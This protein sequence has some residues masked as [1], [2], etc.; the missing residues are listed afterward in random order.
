M[1]VN[2][3]SV[4]WIFL[5][6]FFV[7]KYLAIMVLWLTS[8]NWLFYVNVFKSSLKMLFLEL[9]PE[10]CLELTRVVEWKLTAKSWLLRCGE[11]PPLVLYWVLNKAS[12][13]ITLDLLNM[14]II[15]MIGMKLYSEYLV[16]ICEYHFDLEHEYQSLL[17]MP[18]ALQVKW[19]TG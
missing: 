1:N 8:V 14:G 7:T 2:R 12:P 19:P 16:D 11:F 18:F 15:I 4:K 9:L 5:F 13:N 3:Y 6:Y 10:E 17:E